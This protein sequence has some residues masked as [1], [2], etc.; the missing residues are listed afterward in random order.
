MNGVVEDATFWSSDRRNLSHPTRC[1]R[2][3]VGPSTIY[4]DSLSTKISMSMKEIEIYEIIII[5]S[6]TNLL[7]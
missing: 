3:H 2:H 7:G 6:H 4:F 5:L 1:L